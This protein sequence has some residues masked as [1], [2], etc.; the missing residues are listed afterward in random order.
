MT[1]S[2]VSAPAHGLT[3]F[4]QRGKS[5]LG[6]VHRGGYGDD[7]DVAGLQRIGVKCVTQSEVW[8]QFRMTVVSTYGHSPACSSA[9]MR[10]AL[11]SAKGVELPT[12]FN[13]QRQ[14]DV[15]G[16]MTAILIVFRALFLAN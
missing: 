6:V 4:D 16:P 15:A 8:G 2:P 9:T 10:C 13:R 11:M 3:G 14:A 1:T 12:K 5:A 7:G